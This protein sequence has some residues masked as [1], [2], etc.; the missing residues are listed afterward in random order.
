MKWF[1]I[2][3][4]IIIFYVPLDVHVGPIY[5]LIIAINLIFDPKTAFLLGIVWVIE[6]TKC[7]DVSIGKI[8]VSRH[9]V[10]DENLYSYNENESINSSS[11]ANPV[12]LTSNLNLS[13]ASSYFLQVNL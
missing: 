11:N 3:N 13:S 6:V 1:I 12:T 9:V 7:L 8:F 5:V 2:K 10:F 4:Q